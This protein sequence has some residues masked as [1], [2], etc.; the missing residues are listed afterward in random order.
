MLVAFFLFTLVGLAWLVLNWFLS[1]AA[2]F[3]IAE[4]QRTFGALAAAADLCRTRFGPVAA[5]STWFGLAHL[6]VFFTATSAVAFP[7]AFAGLLPAS[8]VLGGVLLVMF[9]YFATVD[10]LYVGRLAAYVTIVEQPDTP[11]ALPPTSL[12]PHDETQYSALRPQP[13]AG[14]D[15]DELILS[16]APSAT[17]DRR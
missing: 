11:V 17:F 12:P 14:V 1:L 15:P 6:V 4:G 13:E 2:V 7:L 16:D 3:T 9:L 10:F 8:A 5:A